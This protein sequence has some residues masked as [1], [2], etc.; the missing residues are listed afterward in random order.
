MKKLICILVLLLAFMLCLS[1]CQPVAANDKGN[2]DNDISDKD[3]DSGKDDTGKDDDDT[4]D[5]NNGGDDENN[6]GGDENNGGD[7]ENNG[8]DD[9]NEDHP[10]DTE[11]ENFIFD[12]ASELYFIVDEYSSKS[13]TVIEIINTVDFHK[14]SD[15][16]SIYTNDSSAPN[17]HEI[18][19]GNTE[20]ELSK[21][22]MRR[23]NRLDTNTDTDVRYVIYSDGYSI[24]VVYDEDDEIAIESAL[25]YLLELCDTSKL[26]LSHGV[27][28]E[29]VIDVYD[30]YD[31]LDTERENE[32]YKAMAEKVASLTD[33]QV[34]ADLANAMRQFYSLYTNDLVLW[35]ANLYEPSICVCNGLYGESECKNTKYCGTAAFYYSNSARDTIGYLPDVESTFQA[36][37]L[38][39]STGITRKYDASWK[40]ML[41]DE[42]LDG[43][44]AFVR[45][46][47]REDGYFVHPQWTNPGTSRISR[48]L[49]WSTSILKT[50]GASP[51]YTT[52][53]G[54]K[55]IGAP[56]ASSSILSGQL[57]GSTAVACSSVI[58]AN[59]SYLPHLESIETFKTY[60]DGLN[61]RTN[62]YSAG[63]TL[64][65]QASQISA[66]DKA[67][68]LT[69][70]NSLYQ[71]MIDHLNANQNPENGTWD[72]KKPGDDGYDLYFQVNGLMKISGVY[73]SSRPLQ[74]VEQACETAIEAITYD[75]KIGAAV[76]IYNP[77]FA[78]TNIFGNLKG[79]GG[80]EGREK[81]AALR[82]R[83]Y[84][85]APETLIATRDK[86]SICKKLD[87][88]FSYSP[89]YS[90]STSQG[91]PAA[92]PNSVE[93]DVNGTVLSCSG[94]LDYV[95]SALGLSGSTKV[96]LFGDC[97]RLMFMNEIRSLKHFDKPNTN[98]IIEAED[99]ESY[100]PGDIPENDSRYTGKVNSGSNG[101]IIKVVERED[102]EGNALLI[103]SKVASAGDYVYI[104]NQ[105][106]NPAATTFIFEGDFCL[107]SSSSA[108][109]IQIF[110]G[111]AY[112]FSLRVVDGNVRI[113]ECSSATATNS[114]TRDLGVS[115]PLGQWFRV[116]VEYYYDTHDDVRIKFYF[117]GDLTDENGIELIAV[118][119]NY[120]DKNGNKIK[121]P[122]G[123]PS[124]SYTE[125]QIYTISDAVVSL[126]IDN[127]ASYTTTDKYTPA[128]D[129]DGKLTFNI[130]AEGENKVYD[131]ND[132]MLPE[133]ITV[134][135][136]T[137]FGFADGADGKSLEISSPSQKV[138][139]TVPVN[140]VKT[141]G[142][143]VSVS[144]DILCTDA[145]VGST[146]MTLVE[147]EKFGDV[148]GYALVAESG[149]DG[150]Y[151]AIYEYNGA[152]GARVGEVG[153]ALGKQ[154]ELKVDYYSDYRATIF[155]VDGEFVG[156]SSVIYNGGNRRVASK[157]VMSFVGG[158]TYTLSIDNL[159]VERTDKKYVDAVKPDIDSQI[160]DFEGDNSSVI[161]GENSSVTNY[162]G[163]SMAKLE[164]GSGY[165]EIKIPIQ[166]RSKI[167]SA[168]DVELEILYQIANKDGVAHNVAVTDAEGNVI[169]G[170]TLVVNGESIELYEMHRSG[171][172]KMLL[173]T[174]SA[175][176]QIKIGFELSLDKESAYIFAGGK[177]VT[178]TSNFA[179]PENI[180]KE[181]AYLTVSSGKASSVLLVD[182]VKAETL[183]KV[184][185]NKKVESLPNLENE[186][187]L[188]F[189]QS[190]ISSL[191]ARLYQYLGSGASVR[192]QNVL[193]KVTGEYSNAAIFHTKSGNNDKVGIQTT[194]GENLSSYSCVTFETDFKMDFYA[195]DQY[196]YWFYFSKNVE[197]SSD[198]IY[199]LGLG[200]IGGKLYFFDRSASSGYIENRFYTDLTVAD[201]SEW[202]NLKVEY[203]AG[204]K[205]T[206][207]IRLFIDD[208]LIFVSDN[209]YGRTRNENCPASRTG[210]KKVFFYSFANTDADLYLDNMSLTG[211]DATCDDTVGEK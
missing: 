110:M 201:L 118:T 160:T 86:I 116:K 68:G 121:G 189:E 41:D 125:T 7:D 76:D 102:G 74:Y 206:A 139:L 49:N 28:K 152:L 184:Y 163:S 109:P 175:S 177:C 167:I 101:G 170:V 65:A 185:E 112:M 22:A 194:G 165:A 154:T 90:S 2:K 137:A 123:T 150:K 34:G 20:R 104:K 69:A 51:Y 204:D 1:S 55:G 127:V 71:T 132:G 97:E 176:E 151:L 164:S 145:T 94:L 108:Y 31:A 24:A 93:G 91:A 5:K 16:M 173:A 159:T 46:I 190:N 129:P 128:S 179:Y 50:I 197:G 27:V 38:L 88:S 131:F 98:I 169:F 203:Y 87:G 58:L 140:N 11:D 9:E 148:V 36:L 134:S 12:P 59:Q 48:D 8:G 211:S 161:F 13:T 73:G 136:D 15:A 119:D 78:L 19:I 54:L 115:V 56:S 21:T 158:K 135:S 61:V 138:S 99:Y 43:I 180:E 77:W 144:Y 75:K 37:G 67:L 207:R 95:Y 186:G 181:A 202:H 114:V 35:L 6:G 17:K 96:P 10:T 195:G 45:A 120:Y 33:E 111:S 92:V 52:P 3:D 153:I 70:P 105:S 156:A 210:V 155:Y 60:L 89:K 26:V 149:A 40:G 130:D 166:Q 192:V 82:Q 113:Y 85:S 172:P 44:L 141:S 80:E 191:P 208:E 103:D 39:N 122:G 187:T 63:N 79:C 188:T 72:W 42:M 200:V 199:Q 193:D 106:V 23:L 25:S 30:Y 32:V 171:E 81:I 147:S 162:M 83:L 182:N 205:D 84:E 14:N 143:C 64:A 62:S 53:T 196:R 146:V 133:D 178:Q 100:S 198:I 107:A 157:A 29:E 183:Y 66:R 168:V 47:Q 57:T 4:D 117:D 124:K 174:L 18:I 126:M 142:E 209:Y